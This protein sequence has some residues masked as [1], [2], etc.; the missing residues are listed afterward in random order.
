MLLR[1]LTHLP[2]LVG[3]NNSWSN[4]QI[5]LGFDIKHN[6]P[7]R[8]YYHIFTEINQA[9][10]PTDEV[11]VKMFVFVRH[12]ALHCAGLSTREIIAKIRGVCVVV[13]MLVA[14][15]ASIMCHLRCPSQRW[16]LQP[17]TARQGNELRGLTWKRFTMN[18]FTCSFLPKIQ[19]ILPTSA[20]FDSFE[21]LISWMF[22]ISN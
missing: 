13:C 21:C 9:E 5:L 16:A 11:Y 6:D 19:I 8:A 15:L 17:V 4:P 14:L 22:S 2:L 1:K 3:L 18:E 20:M 7:Q 10:R 12:N